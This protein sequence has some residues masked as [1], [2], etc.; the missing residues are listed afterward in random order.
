M[1][2]QYTVTGLDQNGSKYEFILDAIQDDKF[3][4][5]LRGDALTECQATAGDFFEAM[6]NLRGQLEQMGWRLLVKGS[7]I[8]VAVSGMSR[9][10]NGGIKAY[11]LDLGKPTTMSGLVNIFEPADEK[12]IATV[13]EQKEFY[14][15]WLKSL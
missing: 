11:T 6:V 14:S 2:K 12:E 3:K 4:L 13:A 10:M 5:V 9:Q 7:A 1:D 15:S 8:N